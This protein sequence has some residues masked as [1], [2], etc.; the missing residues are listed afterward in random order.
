[1]N[2]EDAISTNIYILKLTCLTTAGGAFP[3]VD[4]GIGADAV[5][6]LATELDAELRCTNGVIFFFLSTEVFFALCSISS[7]LEFDSDSALEISVLLTVTAGFDV[8][9]D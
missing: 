4:I 5:D 1:M 7:S 6:L 9:D 2:E 8:L 3:P